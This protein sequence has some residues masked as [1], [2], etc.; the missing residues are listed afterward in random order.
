MR[1]HVSVAALPGIGADGSFE[2][3]P[4]FCAARHAD[5]GIKGGLAM[6]S[7]YFEVGQWPQRMP[8]RYSALRRHLA[9]GITLSR[10]A[11]T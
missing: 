3:A 5:V 2:V 6:G 9:V 10:Q 7:A 1:R 4:N 11:L 8:A